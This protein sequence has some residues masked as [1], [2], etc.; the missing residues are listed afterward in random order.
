MFHLA[1]DSRL[2]G[3]DVVSLKV[4]DV[5]PQG[6]AIDRPSVGHRK[7]GHPVRSK[8]SEQTRETVDAYIRAS[9]KKAGEFL[10]ASRRYRGR[11]LTTR[12]YARLVSGWIAWI[13]H[14]CTHSLRRT[15]A[16]LSYRK[17]GTYVPSGSCEGIPK[18]RTRH[19]DKDNA[20]S[21]VARQK[22]GGVLIHKIFADVLLLL[23]Q[24]CV[25]SERKQNASPVSIM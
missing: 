14:L 7:T 17:S 1:I 5:A 18:S 2:R 10:F 9:H 16:T 13:Q 19:D 12:Q 20:L 15:K 4:E 23:R 3:C 24:E 11:P 6:V 8:L 21:D 22:E 25:C